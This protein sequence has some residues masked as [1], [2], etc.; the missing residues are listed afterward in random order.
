MADDQMNGCLLTPVCGAKLLKQALCFILL[1]SVVS[2]HED[3]DL[4]IYETV[5]ER[6]ASIAEKLVWLEGCQIF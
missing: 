3:D 5:C 4:K 1:K 6:N 2:L